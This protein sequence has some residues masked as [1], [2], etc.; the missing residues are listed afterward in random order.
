MNS[1]RVLMRLCAALLVAGVA[2]ACTNDRGA[3][4]SVAGPFA[5]A[6][7]VEGAGIHGR[8]T[9][10]LRQMG[11]GGSVRAESTTTE[12]FDAQVR[13]GR[14]RANGL[15]MLVAVTGARPVTRQPVSFTDSAGHRH[16]IEF[17]GGAPG[18]P[19]RGLRA[20]LDGQPVARVE[21]TWRRTGRGF[22]LAHRSSTFF[23]R[24]G[25]EVARED[26]TADATEIASAGTRKNRLASLA[27]T[28]GEVALPAPLM[29]EEANCFTAWFAYAVASLG[30]VVYGQALFAQWWNPKAWIAFGGA[31]VVWDKTLD[32]YLDCMV[33]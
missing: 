26:L 15:G 20:L 25:N 5:A 17:E 2:N 10:T 21:F 16:Q 1:G 12:A 31:V 14:A 33:A 29:A 8:L 27:G 22:I 19:I 3:T 4:R 9:R 24:D 7:V 13:G 11:P 32:T 23:A 18:E 28:V 30:V 6:D